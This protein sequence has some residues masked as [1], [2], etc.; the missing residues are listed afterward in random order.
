MLGLARIGAALCGAAMVVLNAG[1]PAMADEALAARVMQLTRSSRWQL[2]ETVALAF[3]THHPQGMVRIGDRMVMSSVE[4]IEPTQRFPELRDGLDRSAGRGRGHLFEFDLQGRLTRQI[5]LGEGD[6]Y[7]PGGIDF[8]GR[9]IWVPVAEY[10][11]NSRAIVYRVD[12]ATLQASEVLRVADHIGG[13]V[14]ATDSGS[15][16][17]VSWGSRRFY[18]WTLGA[19][20]RAT[21]AN[22]PPER[23]RRLNPSHY[24]DYQDCHYLGANRMLCSGL[25]AYRVA[26]TAPSF[27]LGGI[28]IVDLAAGTAIFQVPVMQWTESGLPMTQNPF[29]AETRGNGLRFYF[30][31]EDD[32][33][34]MFVYDVTP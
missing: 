14:H 6:V 12:P 33:S 26:P 13:V 24:I 15:L 18:R 21:N 28:E 7:H 22:E 3:A 8:D 19:D 16:H 30:V 34:R 20:L 10:R 32:R 5:T 2:V 11:P 31:P 25:N 17:G 1:A 4:I 23:L 9:A 27:A 29:W